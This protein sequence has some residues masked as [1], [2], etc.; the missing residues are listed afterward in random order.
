MLWI[1]TVDAALDAGIAAVARER[2]ETKT[3]KKFRDTGREEQEEGYDM[4][5]LN[6]GERARTTQQ[7]PVW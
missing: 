4:W 5:A 2:G 7:S 3:E 6:V 1:G